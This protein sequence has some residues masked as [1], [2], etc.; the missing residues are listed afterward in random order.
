MKVDRHRTRVER[1]RRE[2]VR[3][4]NE[5]TIK[6]IVIGMDP[7]PPPQ[8]PS[9]DQ[10]EMMSPS[11]NAT[12]EEI[13][14]ATS[15][16]LH[17]SS[18]MGALTPSTHARDG[19][20]SILS[21][22]KASTRYHQKLVHAGLRVVDTLPTSSNMGALTPS[23]DARDGGTSTL[24]RE[25]ASTRCHQKLVI[26]GV[27]VVDTADTA[28]ISTVEDSIRDKQKRR[29]PILVLPTPVDGSV[30]SGRRSMPHSISHI[31]GGSLDQTSAESQIEVLRTL[32]SIRPASAT[33]DIC[34]LDE[35]ASQICETTDSFAQPEESQ[36]MDI[37]EDMNESRDPTTGRDFFVEAADFGARMLGLREEVID[38]R[39]DSGAGGSHGEEPGKRVS[40]RRS[41]IKSA[42][43]DGMYCTTDDGA[44]DVEAT[45]HNYDSILKFNAAPYYGAAT[46]SSG[47]RSRKQNRTSKPSLKPETNKANVD[48]T[49]DDEFD[50]VFIRKYEKFFSDFLWL[51]PDIAGGDLELVENIR[52]AKLKKMLEVAIEA[53][54]TLERELEDLKHENITSKYHG[55]L[56]EA[57]REK[58]AQDEQL[59]QELQT[60][61]QATN[62]MEGRLVWQAISMS[63]SSAKKQ[64]KLLKDLF[65][66]ETDP[67][68]MLDLLPDLP[69][70][71][72]IRDAVR[73]P[74]ATDFSGDKE[75]DLRQFQ[76]DNAFLKAEVQLLEN[77]VAGLEAVAKKHAWVESVFLRLD[78]MKMR[79]LRGEF[80]KKLGVVF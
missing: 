79:E 37:Q 69:V 57:G 42:D 80:E 4:K 63:H 22:E 31:E 54:V 16:V 2:G 74:S 59:H 67:T 21:S 24:S 66:K 6:E 61:Q 34:G 38:E 10:T 52:A 51:H 58:A 75:T 26:A 23:T 65:D 29:P 50:M 7:R 71:Q 1:S 12:G 48:I 30:W 20:T 36:T 8:R 60:I 17:T 32:G 25:K 13:S 39:R 40:F 14:H 77:K 18:N 35:S 62:V 9:G 76:V 19:S 53:E 78:S 11:M 33:S 56:M 55:M 64:Q 3:P 73:A 28:D 15:P 43:P 70:T 46:E 45:H 41:G 5:V 68:D 72:P 27:S 47:N 49:D 44:Q